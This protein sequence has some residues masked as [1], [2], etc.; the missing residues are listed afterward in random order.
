MILLIF[1]LQTSYFFLSLL[2]IRFLF[3]LFISFVTEPFA[4]RFL[5]EYFC[6]DGFSFK[7]S[8]KKKRL[9][10]ALTS[11]HSLPNSFRGQQQ[12]KTLS[13]CSKPPDR[14]NSPRSYS[15]ELVPKVRVSYSLHMSRKPK[16]L[17]V[18]PGILVD[19]GWLICIATNCV[20]IEIHPSLFPG[21]TAKFQQYMYGG[22]PLG[23]FAEF[24]FC[25][26]FDGSLTFFFALGFYILFCYCRCSLQYT[27]AHVQCDC[28]EG[29]SGRAHASRGRYVDY[30]LRFTLTP[31]FLLYTLVLFSSSRSVLISTFKSLFSSYLYLSGSVLRLFGTPLKNR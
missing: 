4:S 26:Y 3:F 6:I 24:T 12:T 30:F 13:N 15:M 16:R 28:G 2:D 19:L 1:T 22:R 10:L 23:T 9:E 18:S 14:S 31:P 7:L 27:L 29:W 11:H 25:F 5:T 17:L 8:L 20:L 21:I